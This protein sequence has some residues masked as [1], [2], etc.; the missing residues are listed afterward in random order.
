MHQ[1]HR[2]YVVMKRSTNS[3]LLGKLTHREANISMSLITH[4]K[5]R[6]NIHKIN[7]LNNL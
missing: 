6:S 7:K 3:R 1:C 5:S 4:H 2:V